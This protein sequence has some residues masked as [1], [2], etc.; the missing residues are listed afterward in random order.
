[1]NADIVPVPALHELRGHRADH[2]LA[3]GTT[4]CSADRSSSPEE[5]ATYA[6]GRQR[7]CPEVPVVLV[8][9]DNVAGKRRIVA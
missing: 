9:A 5:D 2:A 8:Q 7:A 4:D 3:R 6:H 1:M